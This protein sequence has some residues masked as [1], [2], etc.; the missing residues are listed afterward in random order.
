[1]CSPSLISGGECPGE[2]SG[3]RCLQEN[4]KGECPTPDFIV[5]S[6]SNGASN[7]VLNVLKSVYLSLRMVK[8]RELL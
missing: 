2:T 1:M 7:R 6:V 4:V 3:G 8:Y 5:I